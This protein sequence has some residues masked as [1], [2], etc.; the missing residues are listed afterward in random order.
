[1]T[2]DGHELVSCRE[3]VNESVGEDGPDDHILRAA[4]LVRRRVITKTH[5]QQTRR[6]RYYIIYEVEVD[7]DITRRKMRARARRKA[8]DVVLGGMSEGGG[9]A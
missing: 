5:G 4:R 3:I 2:Y 8:K 6:G 7:G 1:M 9:A